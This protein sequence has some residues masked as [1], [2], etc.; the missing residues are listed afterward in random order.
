MVA[1]VVHNLNGKSGRITKRKLQAIETRNRIYETATRLMKQQGFDSMTIEQISAAAAVSVGA[2]YHHFGS[3]NDI[4]NEIFKRADDYFNE[5]VI[6]KLTGNSTA[7]K[8]ICFFNHYAKFNVDLGVD[9]V[10]ALYKTQS[11]FFISSKRLMFKALYD[12]I[13]E[14]IETGDISVD[15]TAE[16][17]TDLLFTAARGVTYNWC[18]HHGQFALEEKMG[19]YMLIYVRSLFWAEAV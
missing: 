3:K 7:E 13:Q 14:T 8:I 10:S 16:E 11:P 12:L 1:D 15:M 5:N 19:K 17:L 4:L 2:F 18:L 9:H 6:G